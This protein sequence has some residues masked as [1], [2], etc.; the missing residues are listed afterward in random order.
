MT[1]QQAAHSANNLL[2]I[3]ENDKYEAAIL[4]F[5]ANASPREIQSFIRQL[6]F[7]A[8][9]RFLPHARIAIEIKLAENAD[10]IADKLAKQTDRLLRF[11][12]GIY[13]FTIALA[14]FA[15][16]QIFVAVMDYCSKNH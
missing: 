11:T 15:I 16:V 10:L 1:P 2:D 6:H 4:E 12:I 14:A 3:P 7:G 9:A 5:L 8:Q 13:V